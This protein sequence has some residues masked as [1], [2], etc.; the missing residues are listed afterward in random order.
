VPLEKPL[1]VNEVATWLGVKPSWVRA[2]ANGHRKPTLPHMKVGA[3]L[4][5]YPSR[6]AKFM[7]EMSR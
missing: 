4:R 1:T 7:E 3:H 6:L 5:F 2:H